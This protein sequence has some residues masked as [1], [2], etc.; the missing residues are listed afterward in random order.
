[1][2]I[3]FG[4]RV[5]NKKTRWLVNNVVYRLIREVWIELFSIASSSPSDSLSLD[6]GSSCYHPKNTKIFGRALFLI[7]LTQLGETNGMQCGSRWLFSI[8]RRVR[9]SWCYEAFGHISLGQNVQNV[10]NVH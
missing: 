8:L 3:H 9:T 6:Y 10:Q 1:M 7:N 5:A 4:R 2:A